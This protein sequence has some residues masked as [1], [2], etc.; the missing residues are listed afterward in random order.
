MCICSTNTFFYKGSEAQ[1][2]RGFFITGFS[3]CH[4]FLDFL[5]IGFDAISGK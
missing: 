4:S 3:I 2:P 5:Y 1:N